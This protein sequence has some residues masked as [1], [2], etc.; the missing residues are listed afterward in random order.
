MPPY[1][2]DVLSR[3]SSGRGLN[4]QEVSSTRLIPV[5]GPG[6]RGGGRGRDRAG[7]VEPRLWGHTDLDLNPLP[8]TD[9]LV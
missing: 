9:S 6:G 1:F 3:A 8:P 7:G 5:P 4:C 2:L